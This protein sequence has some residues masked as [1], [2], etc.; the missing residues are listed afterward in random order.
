[1]HSYGN[2]ISKRIRMSPNNHSD[3]GSL[4]AFAAMICRE[5]PCERLY[6]NTRLDYNIIC[7]RIM[8]KI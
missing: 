1:M 5:S 8:G 2:H 4:A 6:E 7:V 3:F